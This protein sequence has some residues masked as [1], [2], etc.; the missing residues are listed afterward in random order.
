MKKVQLLEYI[1]IM[2]NALKE[3]LNNSATEV[4]CLEVLSECQQCAINIGNDIE[5]RGSSSNSIVHQLEEFC[6]D[7]YLLTQY[8]QNFKELKKR[9]NQLIKMLSVIRNG[10]K[11]QLSTDVKEVVFL[12]YKVSMWDSMESI[13]KAAYQ[14]PY[15]ECHVVP[16]PY[17]DRN[18][19]GELLDMHYEGADYPEY[20]P[21]ESWK[22]YILSVHKPD[23]VFI[24]NPY[25]HY[26]YVTCVHPSFFTEEIKKYTDKLVYVPYFY[27]NKLYPDIHLEMVAYIHCDNIVVQNDWVKKQFAGTIFD[28][29]VISLGNPKLD[30]IL[31]YQAENRFPKELKQYIGK[32]KIV[33]VNTS[34]TDFIENSKFAIE[35]LLFVIKN[36]SKYKE[37]LVIWRPHPLLEASI[38]SMRSDKYDQFVECKREVQAIDNC[39]ID[40]KMNLDELIVACDAY[41]GE[42]KS[43]MV[44][45][46][47]SL[48]KPIFILN[49]N[50]IIEEDCEEYFFDFFKK[51][52]EIYFASGSFP[53]ICR[54][55]LNDGIVEEVFP[56][57]IE[58][59]FDYRYFTDI[60]E[61]KNVL[62]FSPFNAD[63]IISFDLEDK[64]TKK[65]MIRQSSYPN[66]N[67]ILSVKSS[68]WFIPTT[69]ENLLQLEPEKLREH[70]YS[71]PISIIAR[72]AQE[73]GYYSMFAACNIGKTIYIATPTSN[74]VSIFDTV[75]KKSYENTIGMENKGYW[76]M[77]FDG[78]DIWMLPY[79]GKNIMRWNPVMNNVT[80]L[81]SYPKGFLTLEP[82]K[83][84]FIQ[85]V[86]CDTYLL[87]FPKCANMI[88]KIDKVTGKMEEWDINLP[89]KEGQRKNNKYYWGSN[90]YFAKRIDNKIYA[91]TAY[92][93]SL[94]EISLQDNKYKQINVIVPEKLKRQ[95]YSKNLQFKTAKELQDF[96]LRESR[97]R[98]IEN[99]AELLV[100]NKIGFIKEEQDVLLKTMINSDGTAGEKILDYMIRE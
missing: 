96:Y 22:Q 54:A 9:V 26:N 3:I 7:L 51:G 8:L 100:H 5:Q 72:N 16:I 15:V 60:C 64:T 42:E 17:Y 4:D 80:E 30:C 28:K 47:A 25:D 58:S 66:Y 36:L 77:I 14:N 46:F 73:Q 21:I 62:Y 43:S 32:K 29:K 99:F 33:L 95:C 20:V 13:W 31:N 53:G 50:R 86:D 10:I 45:L 2:E 24:H 92:D 61:Y 44:V 98:T 12:P 11:Y 81:N 76:H 89:Y 84:Y 56:I 65:V 83:D 49:N 48:G 1:N 68:L 39:I 37:L 94:I 69:N 85:L 87:A 75:N 78:R 19:K 40:T 88:V 59:R 38:K 6:E 41:I 93:N 82:D 70:Y 97:S 27:T 34:I 18:S 67:R 71:E 57:E 74:V 52:N 35:K 79:K 90:Y 91:M 23:V 63:R 55:R